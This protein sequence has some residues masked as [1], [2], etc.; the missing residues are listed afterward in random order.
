MRFIVR[1]PR[2]M[3]VVVVAAFVLV[4]ATVAA[5][6]R[7]AANCEN[8]NAVASGT[9]H[10]IVDADFNLLGFDI[11]GTAFGGTTTGTNW[12][13]SITPGG[14]IHF[15]GILNFE[16][17]IF[18]DFTTTDEGV[19]TPNGLLNTKLEVISGGTGFISSHGT[20]VLA[21]PETFTYVWE[22]QERGRI[23][24]D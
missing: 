5:A 17:T 19:V 3:L 15:S 14:V 2:L 23:C 21:D 7:P 10:P 16:D 18:G 1:L 22:V 11:A 9:A 8:I 6:P 13:V 4:P 24:I 12:V 20:I